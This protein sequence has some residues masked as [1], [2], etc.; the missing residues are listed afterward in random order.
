M[1]IRGDLPKFNPDVYS[2]VTL[3]DLVVFSIY[4]LHEEGGEITSEDIV[5]ACF[6]LFPQRFSLRK[7][8]HWPDSAVVTRRWSEIRGKGYLLGSTAKGFRLTVKGIRHAQKIAKSLG[9]ERPTPAPSVPTE[10]KTRAGR[11][12]R[13]METSDAFVQYRK[14]GKAARIG[15]F[16]FRSMLLCTMESS[17]ETLKRNLGQFREY[18][19]IHRRRD[20]VNFLDYC[21]DKFA[22]LLVSMPGSRLVAHKRHIEK[23]P[24]K[25]RR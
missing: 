13:A 2:K 7:Y 18:A 24:Q 23:K 11:F 4:Y 21:Q 8:P 15:E 16:D 22:H 3:N 19:E 10:V 17:P 25:A 12:V 14:H 5:S 6:M 1:L 20:L 9:G